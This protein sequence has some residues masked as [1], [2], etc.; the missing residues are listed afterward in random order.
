VPQ[1]S[2]TVGNSFWEFCLPALLCTSIHFFSNHFSLHSLTFRFISLVILLFWVLFSSLSDFSAL[3][4]LLRSLRFK[5][6]C[7][8]HCVLFCLSVYPSTNCAVALY[9]C[10]IYFKFSSMF[11]SDYPLL[12]SN[13]LA[14][15]HHTY[16]VLCRPSF[17]L[18]RILHSCLP[19]P[20]L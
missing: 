2:F 8:I 15:P 4:C 14:R 12:F 16:D 20:R 5:T 6:P 9:T 3:S 19:V 10:L 7:D 13:V 17:S 11:P 18:C 1:I